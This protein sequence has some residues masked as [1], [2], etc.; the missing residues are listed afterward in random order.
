VLYIIT[1]GA[2][3]NLLVGHKK[4]GKD[5]KKEQGYNHRY[6]CYFERFG[7]SHF[8]FLFLLCRLCRAAWPFTLLEAGYR[9]PKGV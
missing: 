9:L 4:E 3:V 1:N 2:E 6:A 7:L 8:A 5:S